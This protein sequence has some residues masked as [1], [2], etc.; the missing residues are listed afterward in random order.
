MK[1]KHLL[2]GV[3]GRR[4]WTKRP[5]AR[6]HCSRIPRFKLTYL[7]RKGGGGRAQDGCLGRAKHPLLDGLSRQRQ[8][9]KKK[10]KKT[11]PSGPGYDRKVGRREDNG[12][13]A[14]VEPGSESHKLRDGGEYEVVTSLS[15]NARQ[16]SRSGTGNRNGNGN[17]SCAAAASD[18]LTPGCAGTALATSGRRVVGRWA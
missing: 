2:P 4:G 6:S 18:N 15:Y 16:G 5:R 9:R 1:R 3:V 7:P 17:S 8:R 14:R 13:N 12:A 10:K 11:G